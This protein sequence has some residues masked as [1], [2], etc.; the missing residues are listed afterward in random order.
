MKVRKLDEDGDMCF[1]HGS[2]DFYEDCADGVAQNVR[3]RLSLWRGQWF[4]DTEEGTPWIQQVLGHRAV[5]EAVLRSR[6]LETPGVV[7]ITSF[8]TVFNPE[9]RKL[10]VSV[11]I[12]TNYGA[13]T[14]SEDI[15]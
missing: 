12:E 9:T 6:I 4:I 11:T 2:A 13:A 8:E 7:D 14:V 5:A 10:T 3:T 1:G 15:E